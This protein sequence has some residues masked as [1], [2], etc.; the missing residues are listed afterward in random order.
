VTGG[1]ALESTAITMQPFGVTT[2]GGFVPGVRRPDEASEPPE[3]PGGASAFFLNVLVLVTFVAGAALVVYGGILAADGLNWELVAALAVLAILAERADMSLYGDSRVSLAI[4]PIFATVIGAGM[5][6]LAIVVPLAILASAHGRPL[7]KTAF[8]FGA[9]MLAA[10]AAAAVMPT[11][12]SAGATLNWPQILLPA[13]IAGCIN[14]AVNTLLVASAIGLSSRTSLPKVWTE[15]FPWLLPHYVILAVIG[16]AVVAA[17]Q[18]MGIWGIA[19]FVAPPLMM[20][21]SIKQ[22]L[23]RTTRNVLD[24][25]HA[26]NQLQRAHEQV[27]D[28]MGRL[29]SAY[30][31]TLRSLSAALDARDSET[32][33]HSAR[34]ADLTLAIAAEMGLEKDT[35]EWRNISWGALLHDVGK[36]AVPDSILRK[37][38]ALTDD[39][40]QA[41]RSHAAAG[42]EILLKIDFLE[43]AGQIVL[44]HH[45]RFDGGGYPRGLAGDEIPLGARIFT[46]ADAFDAMTSDRTYRNAMPAEQALAEVL[47]NSGTQFDPTAVRAFLSVYQKRFVGTVHH[48]H[49]TSAKAAP[50]EHPELSESLKQAIA[51]AAGLDG[52]I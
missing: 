39:E 20:R 47:R 27:T 17:H 6:G 34:V 49:L 8:N 9:L 40:W 48:G 12:Y 19:V 5:P 51:E 52:E 24:L 43:T 23:D 11:T 18:A 1:F 32:G 16:T 29:S 45:E 25:R 13:A 4:V 41:M 46:I 35:D 38:G 36:I 50:G 28:A 26:H 31:G 33:G 22:Y 30:D 7:R 44:S 2:E 15:H 21:L 10:A 37:P 14:F 3:L 42:Y